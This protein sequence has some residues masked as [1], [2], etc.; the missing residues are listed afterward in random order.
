[1]EDLRTLEDDQ[2]EADQDL[3]FVLQEMIQINFILSDSVQ[4]SLNSE[5]LKSE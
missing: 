5:R 3:C 4:K 2:A 1:M